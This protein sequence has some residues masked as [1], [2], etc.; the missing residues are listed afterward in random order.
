MT[1]AQKKAT[2]TTMLKN[3]PLVGGLLAVAGPAPSS[4]Q[5]QSGPRSAGGLPGHLQGKPVNPRKMK[6]FNHREPY[7]RIS[8]Q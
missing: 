6:Y 2:Q 1:V 4:G 5:P 7:V 3:P 8:A